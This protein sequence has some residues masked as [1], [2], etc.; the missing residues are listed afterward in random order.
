MLSLS[1]IRR[2][3][4]ADWP[5]IAKFGITPALTLG[6]LLLMAVIEVS[7]LNKV[8]SENDHVVDVVMPESTELTE[9][10]ARFEK[11]DADLARLVLAEAANPGKTDIAAK[12]TSIQADLQKVTSDLGR[13]RETQ[14]GHANL[15]QVEAARRDVEQYSSA[16]EVVISMLGVDF[17]SAAAMIQPF[18]HNAA[19]VSQNLNLIAR[20][21]AKEARRRAETIS[22]DVTAT[23]SAFSI[24]VIIA[25]SGTV[26]L[27]AVVGKKTVRSIREIADATTRLAG[28]D[29]SLDI[30]SLDR[31]DEL[32][33]VVKALE[34]FRQ[35]ALEAKRLQLIEQ[36]SRELHIAKTAAENASQAKSD[37]L[38]NMSHEL[39]TPLNAILGYAQL[40]ENDPG[41]S[42]KHL[43][44]ARTIHQ[45]GTHLLALITD[46]LDLSKIEA[47]KL[48]LFPAPL[49]LRSLARGIADMI[50]V[51]AADK[52]LRF[53]SEV[54]PDLP[55]HVLADE[56]RLR[57]VMINLL[58]NS[59]KFTSQ[60][61]VGL[62]IALVS[63]DENRA[64][65]RFEIRDTGVGIPADQ[66]V[67]IF[68]PFE[69]VGDVERWA[70]GTGLGLS[71]SR[72]LVHLMNSEIRVESEV[73]H[74]STFFFELVVEAAPAAGS[75]AIETITGYAGP[76]RTVLIVDDTPA[77]RAVLV[78]KLHGLGFLTAEAGDGL[79]GLKQAELL[80][81]DLVLMDRRAIAAG[82]PSTSF[83]RSNPHHNFRLADIA[84]MTM[85]RHN[86]AYERV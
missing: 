47:G 11:A 75:A 42:D 26:L 57:Q 56:K 5:L 1:S 72:Q 73:G 82:R 22:G 59:I 54:S 61:E 84:S 16:V 52:G 85:H 27:T 13:F 8:R 40:M 50:R 80:T 76:R 31:K 33:T 21:G 66:L 12:V 41:I 10:R 38:A 14:T 60:G 74:G 49:E 24:I 55:A 51:R 63:G 7:A 67:Q 86:L 79:E 70:G 78:E 32:G 34:T 28:A 18:H 69:Q 64:R 81:P 71:I 37:F 77:N 17:S 58:G 30:S 53:R 65:V 25:F 45:S 62:H 4:L 43:V 20:S 23:T 6:L 15:A 9:V 35:Q 29:Y 2:S 44:G 83:C 39:R 48:E 46:I 19:R 68:Q 3:R 36:E